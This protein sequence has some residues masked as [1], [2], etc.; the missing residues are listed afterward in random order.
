M[1]PYQIILLIVLL[2]AF[3]Y[4]S[5]VLVVLSHAR[6]FR[7]RLRRRTRAMSII[8]SEQTDIL[9]SLIDLFRAQKLDFGENTSFID[10]LYGLDFS[11][12]NAA[13]NAEIAQKIKATYSHLSYLAQENRWA[14]RDPRVE[15]YIE[16]FGEL[17]RNLRQTVAVY[18]SD[19]DALNYWLGV[20]TTAWLLWL[21]GYRKRKP[22]N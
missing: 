11:K 20:P 14:T 7:L 22:I 18:N 6:E 21:C 4:V 2:L 15:T 1:E 9:T 16:T 3:F 10:E 13:A 12:P 19:V 17:D 5:V 8:L